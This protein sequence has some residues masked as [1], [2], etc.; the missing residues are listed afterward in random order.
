[1]SEINPTSTDDMSITACLFPDEGFC[2]AVCELVESKRDSTIL[3]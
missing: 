1:M 3:H 2:E